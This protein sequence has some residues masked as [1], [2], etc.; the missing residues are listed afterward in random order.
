MLKF[1][2][3]ARAIHSV[4]RSDFS[5]FSFEEYES[6]IKKKKKTDFLSSFRTRRT[7]RKERGRK[8]DRARCG[9]RGKLSSP[10]A[11]YY[12]ISVVKNANVLNIKGATGLH[13][14]YG[15]RKETRVS[16]WGKHVH[17]RK[18]KTKIF[19]FFYSH[20][21]RDISTGND[22]SRF[23]CIFILCCRISLCEFRFS[24]HYG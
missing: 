16:L 10:M 2:F 8:K 14:L 23:L 3:W 13:G 17:H 15:R 9:E 22:Q 11:F 18:K 7:R 4:S 5:R 1:K 12:R 21:E 6:K 24:E 20:T 19:F